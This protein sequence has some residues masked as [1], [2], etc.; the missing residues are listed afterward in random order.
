MLDDKIWIS[1]LL[2]GDDMIEF[3]EGEVFIRFGLVEDMSIM[4]HF[5]N[6]LIV[7]GLS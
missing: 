5:H 6:L 3:F 1:I 2:F 7:H 4:H